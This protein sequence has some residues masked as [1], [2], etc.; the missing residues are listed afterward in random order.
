MASEEGNQDDRPQG[1]FSACGEKR[2]KEE[3]S[4]EVRCTK[5]REAVRISGR[6]SHYCSPLLSQRP[7]LGSPEKLDQGLMERCWKGESSGYND[8]GNGGKRD[9]KK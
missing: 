6:K 4:C 9:N 7:A 5:Q 3:F 8:T 1:Q 2:V